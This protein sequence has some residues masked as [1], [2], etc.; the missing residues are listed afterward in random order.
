MT[1]PSPQRFGLDTSFVLRLL[2]GEPSF[3][4]A[5]AVKRLDALRSAGE[6]AVVGD[7]VVCEAYFALQHHYDVP[8]QVA[9]D[10]LRE[11]LESDEIA[12]IG[13][14]LHICKGICK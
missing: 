7:L 14:S 3:L 12:A 9:L 2:T 6:R 4:A 8:K 11:F 5:K 1:R 13:E 10:K